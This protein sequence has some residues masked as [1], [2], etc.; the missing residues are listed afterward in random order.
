MIYRNDDIEKTGDYVK[1]TIKDLKEYFRYQ[2]AE[3]C[4]TGSEC[5]YENFSDNVKTIIDLLDKLYYE[6]ENGNLSDND[7]IKVTE[8]PM[9]GLFIEETEQNL[10]ICSECGKTM[11]EGYCIENGLE[12]YCSDNCLHKHYT[13]EE[14]NKMYDNGN[15]DSYYTEW[16]EE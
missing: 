11:T 1:G 8:H 5:D 7:V 2:I 15:G 9:G 3:Q 16:E 10:R 13:E 14:Y 4:M 6:T 12:Y